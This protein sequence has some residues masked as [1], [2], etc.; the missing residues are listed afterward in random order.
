MLVP[1]ASTLFQCRE[2]D[3]DGDHRAVGERTLGTRGGRELPALVPQCSHPPHGSLGPGS[4]PPRCLSCPSACE[5]QRGQ[6]WQ[7]GGKGTAVYPTLS[8]TLPVVRPPW[9]WSCPSPR[10]QESTL[11]TGWEAAQSH[12]TFSLPPPWLRQSVAQGPAPLVPNPA[13]SL[14]L[15]PGGVWTTSLAP[16]EDKTRLNPTE[17][18]SPLTAFTSAAIH[19][20]VRCHPTPQPR[21]ASCG[22]LIPAQ[23]EPQGHSLPRVSPS[24]H[25]PWEQWHYLG[26][27]VPAVVWGPEPWRQGRRL[28]LAARGQL[29]ICCGG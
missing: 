16:A 1:P 22:H 3:G 29:F 24:H 19:P 25:V 14:D 28:P 20:T 21:T 13:S 7:Q 27:P 5:T 10:G 17:V 6:R 4:P 2:S 23:R 26:A 12:T 8:P 18:L 15:A 11:H 9:N